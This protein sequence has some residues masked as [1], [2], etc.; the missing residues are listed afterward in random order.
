MRA[1]LLFILLLA[2]VALAWARGWRPPDRYNPWAP[3]DLTAKPDVFLRYKLHRLGDDPA[4]CR[5]AISKAG[6]VFVPLGDREEVNG[7]GWRDAVR[8]SAIGEA[9]LSSPA[10][11]GCPLAV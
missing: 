6:A 2:L 9:R 5:T 3:L 11:L 8:L 10:A 4:L 7:C 1:W